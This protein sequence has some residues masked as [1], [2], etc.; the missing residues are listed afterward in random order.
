VHPRHP[1]T[2][3]F[4]EPLPFLLTVT[5]CSRQTGFHTLRY[6]FRA[7][8][9]FTEFT[10]TRTAILRAIAAGRGCACC[11]TPT[12]ETTEPA[13]RTTAGKVTSNGRPPLLYRQRQGDTPE[14]THARYSPSDSHVAQGTQ[15]TR[16]HLVSSCRGSHCTREAW[17]WVPLA[18]CGELPG[19]EHP[20]RALLSQ[21]IVYSA[22]HIT[23][24][25]TPGQKWA[26]GGLWG[27]ATWW[28]VTAWLLGWPL[29]PVQTS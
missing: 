7:A 29:V 12:E 13:G 19:R 5:V 17:G 9:E 1:S 23:A 2:F 18:A 21:G 20:G 6:Y 26:G 14:A 16:G 25:L 27:I 11:S 15:K 28:W 22:V 4:P 24:V 8:A 3:P 10:H